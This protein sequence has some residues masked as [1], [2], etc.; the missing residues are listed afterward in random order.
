MAWM[1]KYEQLDDEQK[2]FVDQELNKKGNIWIDGHAGSGKS[3]LLLHAIK[4]KLSENP[5]ANVCIVVYTLSL[6]DMFQTGMNDLK[7]KSIPIMTHYQFMKNNNRYDYIFSDEVQDLPEDVL[8]AMNNRSTSIFVAGDRNQ[9]IYQNAASSDKIGQIINARAFK[10]TRIHRLTRS[11]INAV[12]KMLPNLDIFGAKRDMTKKDVEIRLLKADNE[13]E[14]VRFIWEKAFEAT[15]NGYSA[16]ILLPKH[17]D[18]FKFS[19]LLLANN[20]KQEWR[21]EK[22]NYGKTNYN[23]LNRH[24]N[25]EGIKVE[26]IG[27]GHGSFHDSERNH[28]VVIMTYHS[29]KGMDFDNVFLP[30]MSS[31]LYISPYEEETLFMVAM[32]RSKENLFITYSNDLYHLAKRFESNCQKISFNENSQNNEDSFDFDF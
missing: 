17:D 10:L 8:V 29:A 14:E 27:N 9:S 32:T 3:I 13:V 20:S 16:V 31:D 22:N 12:S 6:K 7:M 15:S 24:F 1:V 28:H 4:Q 18:I 23:S 5:N 19:N 25:S 11:I 21:L 30:F 2:D 26:Y